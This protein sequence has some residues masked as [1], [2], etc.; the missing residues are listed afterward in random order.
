MLLNIDSLSSDDILKIESSINYLFKLKN[1][2]FFNDSGFF[3]EGNSLSHT[4][5]YTLEGFYESAKI[6]HRQDILDHVLKCM[7]YICDDIEE[8]IFSW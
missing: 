2:K 5:A 7:E 6:L 1:L 8:K 4:V 3:K